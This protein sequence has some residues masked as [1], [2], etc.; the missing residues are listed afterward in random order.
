MCNSIDQI[1]DVNVTWHLSGDVHTLTIASD[2]NATVKIC[3]HCC[4]RQRLLSAHLGVCMGG[5]MGGLI[6][7]A[8]PLSVNS[9]AL[10]QAHYSTDLR[11][12]KK[13]KHL[14]PSRYHSYPAGMAMEDEIAR[15]RLSV[16]QV[17]HDAGYSNLVMIV[18]HFL[19]HRLV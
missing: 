2:V 10:L 8:L 17:L 11:I 16:G 12:G 3:Q 13:P 1:L 4:L 5:C 7:L 14:A 6:R 15:V 9:M 19:K 18:R